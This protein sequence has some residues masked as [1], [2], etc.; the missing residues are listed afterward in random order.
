MRTIAIFLMLTAALAPAQ[1]PGA[2]N[3]RMAK[4]RDVVTRFIASENRVS[5]LLTR[6]NGSS[7]GRVHPVGLENAVGQLTSIKSELTTDNLENSAE[8][9]ALLKEKRDALHEASSKLA[10]QVTRVKAIPTI[11]KELRALLETI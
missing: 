2:G 11:S 3:P 1:T 4:R 7:A 10:G 9:Q 6:I 5:D 8:V